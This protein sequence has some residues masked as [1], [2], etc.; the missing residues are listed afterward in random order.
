MTSDD[1]TTK[2]TIIDLKMFWNF[3]VDNFLIWNFITQKYVWMF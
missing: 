2:I 3:V 1:K